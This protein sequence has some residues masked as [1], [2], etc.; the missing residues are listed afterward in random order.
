M[1]HLLSPEGYL[2][3]VHVL[4]VLNRAVMTMAKHVFVSHN[5]LRTFAKDIRQAGHTADL[6]CAL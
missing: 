2:S 6:L 4:A 3:W 5:A 1:P